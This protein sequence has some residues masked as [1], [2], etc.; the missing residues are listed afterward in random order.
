VKD[1]S[2]GKRAA[3]KSSATAQPNAGRGSGQIGT[4]ARILRSGAQSAAVGPVDGSVLRYAHISAHNPTSSGTV[5][6]GQSCY[7]LR[8]TGYAPR[9]QVQTNEQKR[10]PDRPIRIRENRI[11]K[12]RLRGSVRSAVRSS[13]RLGR[14]S[15]V[16][17]GGFSHTFLTA[18][19]KQHHRW[20]K[21]LKPSVLPRQ[22]TS[23]GVRSCV[24]FLLGCHRHQKRSPQRQLTSPG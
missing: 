5:V 16:N 4:A 22:P 19:V 23:V 8:S 13:Q 2:I 1:A 7:R 20:R 24:R 3:R 11:R 14:E 9:D 15:E 18:A 21:H 6:C 10:G 17:N 12:R